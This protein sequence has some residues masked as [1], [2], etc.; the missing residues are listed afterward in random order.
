MSVNLSQ[1]TN[2]QSFGTWLTRTNQITKIIT[3]NTVTTGNTSSGGLTSGNGTVNGYFGSNTLFVIENLRGGNVTTSNT[4]SVSSNAVFKFSTSN[5][6]YITSNSVSTNLVVTVANVYVE[7]NSKFLNSVSMSNALSVTGNATLSNTLA[8][9]GNTTLSN[10]LAVTGNATLSN[11]L[12]V[13]GNTTLSNTL[14]VTGNVNL[15]NTLAVTGNATLSNTLNVT[16][17]TTLSNTL[18]VTGNATLSNTLNVTGNTTLSNTLNVTGNVNL[19]NTLAVIGNTTLS[20][21]LLVTGNVNLSNTLAVIGNTTLSNTITLKDIRFSVDSSST[22]G[23]TTH[24]PSKIWSREIETEDISITG[25][26]TGTIAPNGSIIPSSNLSADL[27]SSSKWFEDLYVQSITTNSITTNTVS[28]SGSTNSNFNSGLLFIDTTNSRIGIKNTSPGSTLTVNGSVETT[29]SYILPDSSI[30]SFSITTI[31]QG[32]QTVDTFSTLTYRSAEYTISVKD[33][34]ANAYQITKI[35][36]VNDDGI[37]Y[38]TEYGT[39]VTNTNLGLFSTTISSG[40]VA[41]QV[42]PTS[43]STTM[44]IHR[45][46]LVV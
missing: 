44:K 41:L 8:V 5:L 19:S 40:D 2:T 21:T 30:K 26:I 18:A 6:V 35:L 37:S 17:N 14:L 25:F 27:G 34:N 39:V 11:T 46:T 45:T 3:A 7:G 12:N 31:G 38:A 16:G 42:T 23:N 15:S 29:N 22:V 28:V 32:L 13:T 24:R 20:N 33:N 4:L 36:V 1:V 43:T 9:T 10:T